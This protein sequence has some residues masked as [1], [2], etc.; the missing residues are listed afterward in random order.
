[1]IDELR[2]EGKPRQN[3]QSRKWSMAFGMTSSL[4]Q[5]KY[6]ICEVEVIPPRAAQSEG[7]GMFSEFYL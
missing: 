5:L 3:V 6:W 4:V 1:M 2:Q 7:P